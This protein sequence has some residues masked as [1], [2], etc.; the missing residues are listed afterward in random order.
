MAHFFYGSDA[1]IQSEDVE[2]CFAASDH[3]GGSS[4]CKGVGPGDFHDLLSKHQRAAS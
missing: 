3:D 1:K 2:Y 4:S